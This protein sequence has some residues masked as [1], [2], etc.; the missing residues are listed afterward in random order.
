MI[1]IG[2]VGSPAGGKSTVA[3][4]LQ[5]RGATWINADLVARSVLETPAIQTQLVDRFGASIV[6]KDGMVDR[7]KLADA[8]FGDD[9]RSRQALNYLTG[10]THPATRRR[11]TE[12]LRLL[13]RENVQCVILDV[14]LLFESGWETSCDTVWCVDCPFDLRSA[15]AVSRGWDGA[16]LK[17]REMN[18]LAIAEKRRRSN[19]VLQNDDSRA[20][21]IR[22]VDAAYQSLMDRSPTDRSSKR[23]DH[24]D[25]AE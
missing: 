25:G 14:P 3:S 4:R 2:I 23:D 22:Q 6:G 18:Q 13:A 15:R 1:V 21:L 17:R 5:D 9:E 10:L 16:E 11:I 20:S 12:Q 24:C 7:A 19:L 8:V